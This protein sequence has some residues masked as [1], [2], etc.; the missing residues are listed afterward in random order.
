MKT[1]R[2]G[3]T[4][5]IILLVVGARLGQRPKV[6]VVVLWVP[7]QGGELGAPDVQILMP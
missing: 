4:K 1:W 2:P 3:E 7:D 5:T 6:R